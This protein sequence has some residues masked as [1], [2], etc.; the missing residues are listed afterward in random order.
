M[1][2]AARV[3]P[4]SVPPSWA[5]DV[6]APSAL[7]APAAKAP[8]VVPASQVGGTPAL[9]LASRA[10]GDGRAIPQYGFKPTFVARPPAAG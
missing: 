5:S 2:Q 1:S 8:T 4:L 6:P 9:P 10:Q 7:V 3:G